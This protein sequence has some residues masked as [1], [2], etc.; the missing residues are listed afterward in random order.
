MINS[1]ED[2]I[3]ACVKV[4]PRKLSNICYIVKITSLLCTM[5]GLIV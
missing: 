4:H 5:E 2:F 3:I 1:E